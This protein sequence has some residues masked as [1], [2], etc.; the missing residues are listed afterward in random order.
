[1]GLLRAHGAGWS[2]R[3]SVRAPGRG[4]GFY[5]SHPVSVT[6]PEHELREAG[7][8]SGSP[9]PLR[10]REDGSCSQEQRGRVRD[11]PA[12][13]SPWT[14][15]REVIS[16]PC[17]PR[18]RRGPGSALCRRPGPLPGRR[19]LRCLLR[20]APASQSTVWASWDRQAQSCVPCARSCQQRGSRVS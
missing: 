19:G 17:F 8:W 12:G 5:V 16:G 13:R 4:V 11:R 2:C 1:M 3:G 18:V 20:E 6:P 15:G 14:A 7:T 10:G 9:A